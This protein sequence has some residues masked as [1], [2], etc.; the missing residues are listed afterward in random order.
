MA[1][2]KRLFSTL[3]MDTYN[4]GSA[5]FTKQ[6]LYIYSIDVRCLLL[7]VQQTSPKCKGDNQL[8]TFKGKPLLLKQQHIIIFCIILSLYDGVVICWC[9]VK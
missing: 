6:S 4:K 1:F 8:Q 3:C 2:I 9:P 7:L 5:M